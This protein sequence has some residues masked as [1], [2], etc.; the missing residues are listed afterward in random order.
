MGLERGRSQAAQGGCPAWVQTLSMGGS[1]IKLLPQGNLS[2][3][4]ER[5]A[6]GEG[7]PVADSLSLLLCSK[8][9]EKGGR[10]ES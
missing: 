7:T 5:L 2:Q 8:D 9:E 4:S 6:L 1:A 3:V 10:R